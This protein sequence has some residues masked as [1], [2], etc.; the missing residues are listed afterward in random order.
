[1]TP[2]AV[3]LQDLRR[4]RQ[5]RQKEM[6]FLLEID[7]TYLSA[8]E[9]GRKSPPKIVF[10][11]RLAAKLDLNND[12]ARQLYLAVQYSQQRYLM[13]VEAQP[14][15]YELVWNIMNAIGKLKPGQINVIDEVLKL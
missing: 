4:S 12:E 15:E 7:V 2:I 5:M 3:Y 8:I 13:P 11:E 9:N 14:R 6:A 1:M 10:F